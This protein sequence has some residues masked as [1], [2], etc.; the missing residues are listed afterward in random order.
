MATVGEVSQKITGFAF[1]KARGIGSDDFACYVDM[2]DAGG[3]KLTYVDG[4]SYMETADG[5][6]GMTGLVMDE[7]KM[8]FDADTVMPIDL[9]DFSESKIENDGSATVLTLKGISDKLFCATVFGI[10]EEWFETAEDYE[11]FLAE[12]NCDSENY[13]ETYKIDA[14]GKVI[15]NSVSYSYTE[16]YDE[17]TEVE[18]YYEEINTIDNSVDDITPPEDAD[19]Y[20]NADE[21]IS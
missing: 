8:L 15:M 13:T 14:D 7:I 3:F 2:M 4:V 16:L 20:I 12:V 6:V 17:E 1:A 10:T 21:L 5:K 11:A 18:I 19:T 9:S